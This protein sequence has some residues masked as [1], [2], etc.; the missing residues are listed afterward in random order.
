MCRL[1]LYFN[2]RLLVEEIPQSILIKK[3]ETHQAK[4]GSYRPITGQ[5][6]LRQ[7]PALIRNKASLTWMR[8]IQLPTQRF[9]LTD[10]M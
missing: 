2:S 3:H 10:V 8:V 1:L 6:S 7:S 4:C 9:H 5:T